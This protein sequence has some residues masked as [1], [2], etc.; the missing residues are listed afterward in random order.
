MTAARQKG[1]TTVVWV[2][3]RSSEHNPGGGPSQSG[4]GDNADINRAVRQEAAA[5][6][7]ELVIWDRD[8]Y[9]SATG[10]AAWFFADGVHQTRLGSWGMAD[11]ISRHVAALDGRPCPMPWGPGLPIEASCPSPDGLSHER[12]G[13]PDIAALYGL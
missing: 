8:R 7:P 9:T 13:V 12:G 1:F 10:A 2:A 11:W 6:F 3:M 5:R 4:F